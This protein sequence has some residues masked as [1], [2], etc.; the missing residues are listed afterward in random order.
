MFEKLVDFILNWRNV[1]INYI[2]YPFTRE[3]LLTINLITP[4]NYDG[5]YTPQQINSTYTREIT[6]LEKLYDELKDV[7]DYTEVTL[8]IILKN[9]RCQYINICSHPQGWDVVNLDLF[10]ESLI[11]YINFKYHSDPMLHRLKLR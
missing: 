7:D 4:L 3:D 11:D 1:I 10:I 6:S 2:E 9:G 8:Q 5:R